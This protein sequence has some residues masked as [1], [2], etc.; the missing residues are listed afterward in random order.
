METQMQIGNANT[1][2]LE[3]RKLKINKLVIEIIVA[4]T[5]TEVITAGLIPF[6]SNLLY[7]IISYFCGLPMH[8][9]CFQRISPS[10]W[11]IRQRPPSRVH[12]VPSPVSWKR[13]FCSR[14][15]HLEEQRQSAGNAI[16]LVFQS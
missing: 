12:T 7:Y 10:R 1:N 3:S 6:L 2:Y 13:T 9:T 14:T 15:L 11:T 8:L 16:S 4:L 5:L